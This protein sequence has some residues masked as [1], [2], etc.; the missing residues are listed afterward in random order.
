[1][2]FFKKNTINIIK[3][4]INFLLVLSSLFFFTNTYGNE[5]FV[6]F[7]DSLQGEA[8]T[9]NGEETVELNEFDQI[10]INQ[11][12]IVGSNSSAT[13]SFVDNS[14]LTLDSNTEFVVEKFED[15][16]EEPT[17]LLSMI[18]GK[19]SFESGRIA[20]AAKGL[21][22]I[23]LPGKEKNDLEIKSSTMILGLRGTLITGSNFETSKKVSLI[24][25]SLGKVGEINIDYGGE[26]ITINE[27]SSGINI[28]EN[29]EIQNTILNEEESAEVKNLIKEITIKS[30]TQSEE[31]IERAIAKQLA[32]GTIPDANGDGIAD[33][34]DVEA[35]KAE[36]LGLKKSK[37][38]FVV[39]QST[40]DLSLLS[41][42][43]VNSNSDQSMGLMENMMENN[44]ESASLLMT[45]IV[46]QDFDIF[47][48]VSTAET[49]NFEN[50]RET[51]VAEMIQDDS[52]FV[53]DTMAQM[54]AVGDTEMG[55]YMMNEIA[56]AQPID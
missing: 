49:G 27:P 24:E 45:E 18:N 37:L 3:I 26:T 2:Y 14:F 16:S 22:K 7:V 39:E 36:L 52:A 28:S 19:F 4:K 21:M 50:L 32:S 40:D 20:K 47:S 15:T 35:Y 56:N 42:I 31:K 17:F 41:D 12:I 5:K 8:F 33:S 1:M 34:S 23:L 30:A 13:I 29:N 53:A 46:E 38:D 51:I 25:D 54:M 10:F 43:I 44:S 11:K 48:H 55:T 6:G 9:T